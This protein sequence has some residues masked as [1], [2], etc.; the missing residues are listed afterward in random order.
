MIGAQP[1][2]LKRRTVKRKQRTAGVVSVGE[3]RRAVFDRDGGQCRVYRFLGEASFGPS[4]LLIRFSRATEMHEL[5]FKSLGGK[6]TVENCIA[7]CG[8]HHRALHLHLLSPIGTNANRTLL[9]LKEKP[10]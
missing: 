4:A 7:V 1:T 10:A 6:V 2:P 5:K 3:V 9:F 8:T